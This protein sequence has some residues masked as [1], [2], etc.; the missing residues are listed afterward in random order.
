MSLRVARVVRVSTKSD[1]QAKSL[2]RQR[3]I[4]DEIAEAIGGEIQEDLLFEDSLS[5]R[6]LNRPELVRLTNLVMAG[7]IDAIVVDR[8]DRLSRDTETL[9]RLAKVFLEKK[10]RFFEVSKGDL[11]HAEIH[12]DN[13]AEWRYFINAGVSGEEESRKISQRVL[14]SHRYMR[15][16]N[17]AGT[18]C[19]FGWDRSDDGFYIHDQSPYTQKPELNLTNAEAAQQM[20]RILFEE[21]QYLGAT[22][23]IAR[24]LN[25]TWTAAGFR[26]WASNPVHQGH[27]P[28]GRFKS[29]DNKPR[30]IRYNTHSEIAFITQADAQMMEFFRK[31]NQRIWGQNKGTRCYPTG[32]LV[33]CQRC[34]VPADHGTGSERYIQCRSYRRKDIRYECGRL[35]ESRKI[36]TLIRSDV[37]LLAIYA[38]CNRA[39]ELSEA[40][41]T[42]L[43][44]TPIDPEI[45]R[46]QENIRKIQN[47]IDE[48]GDDGGML[49][50]KI[51]QLRSQIRGKT[52]ITPSVHELDQQELKNFGSD[53]SS[54]EILSPEKL[55]ILF[56]KFIRRIMILDGKVV[57]IETWV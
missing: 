20:L 23:R 8:I 27:T 57:Q 32:G 39:K 44:A 37:E 38:L 16:Q 47:L 21:K 18:R 12:L 19:P 14:R 34:G 30:D 15:S 56:H 5:G 41:I 17:K 29:G 45:L 10:I 51:I 7:E 26:F 42:N 28:Y 46:L 40:T 1:K 33:Y 3:F 25:H 9:A 2:D 50:Q 22:H 6:K 52:K 35:K 54:W 24:E 36:P 13:P 53:P 49:G 11:P 4:V 31:E 43:S 48:M 55:K